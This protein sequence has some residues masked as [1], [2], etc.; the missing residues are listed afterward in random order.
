MIACQED[1][2]LADAGAAGSFVDDPLSH[3]RG[4]QDE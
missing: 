1:D 3:G 4:D 2:V